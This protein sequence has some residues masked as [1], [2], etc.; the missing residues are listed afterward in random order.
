M[1]KLTEK[2]L[3]SMKYK[4]LLERYLELQELYFAPKKNSK[5]SSKPSST[6]DEIPKVKKNQSLR[7][8]S[9]KPS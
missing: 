3:E 6:D 8:K 5:N 4:E 1:T 7:E 2:D 9:D